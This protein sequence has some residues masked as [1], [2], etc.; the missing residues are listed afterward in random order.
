M[1]ILAW[2]VDFIAAFLFWMLVL[3]LGLVLFWGVFT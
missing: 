1:K 2:I 3:P